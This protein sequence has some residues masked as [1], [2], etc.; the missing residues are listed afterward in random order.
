MEICFLGTSFGAPSRERRQ[1]SVLIEEGGSLYLFDAGGGALD[2]LIKY[3]FDPAD[4]RAIFISHLHGDHMNGLHDIINLADYFGIDCPVYL[5]ERRGIEAFAAFAFFQHR[6]ECEKIEFRL[7]RSGE[8]YRDEN[9]TVGGL[10]T[11]HMAAAGLP[12][13]AF[14]IECGGKNIT[15]TGDLSSK[16]YDFPARRADLLITEC[17]HFSAA[18]VCEKIAATGTPQ[19]AIIHIAP[20]SKYEEFE[21]M[22][23]SLSFTLLL[24]CDG[25][26]LTI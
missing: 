16:L 25:D 24:P 23:N 17:A 11:E 1:Q 7:I 20:E 5:S 8:F 13:Y 12:C 3:G 22:K 4:L 2:A 21:A 10:L 26:R 14:Y 18:A 15:I 19:A 9:I 6:R